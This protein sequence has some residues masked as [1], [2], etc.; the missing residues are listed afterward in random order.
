MS[1]VSSHDRVY[2][3]KWDNVSPVGKPPEEA[4]LKYTGGDFP[5]ATATPTSS[6]LADTRENRIDSFTKA[7]TDTISKAMLS[8][9]NMTL[10]SA[11]SEV[12][13]KKE[14]EET[15]ETLKS[16]DAKP[17]PESQSNKP[18][19]MLSPKPKIRDLSE[20]KNDTPSGP[21]T[22]DSIR[23]HEPKTPD[24]CRKQE[25]KTPDISRKYE[26]LEASRKQEP[27]TP[28]SRRIE[29]KIGEDR[30]KYP[31]HGRS[32]KSESNSSISSKQQPHRF[33][34]CRIGNLQT[35]ENLLRFDDK[36]EIQRFF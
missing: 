8:E 24:I 7:L 25:P 26:T 23:K 6:K 13:D 1:P 9:L 16:P 32:R 30:K 2:G 4:H 28:D 12:V 5:T 29:G 10:E 14:K 27:K 34:F 11:K 17:L 18:E 15:A 20:K 33:A 22:P 31:E 19:I 3:R 35:S 36:N 21:K